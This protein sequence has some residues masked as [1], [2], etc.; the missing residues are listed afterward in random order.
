ML[1]AG[2]TPPDPVELLMGPKLGLLLDMAEKLGFTQVVIDG[3][4]L[5]GL[6]DAVVL[7]NQVQHVVF[8]VKAAA[9]KKAG[10][11]D[12]LR[13]LRH[14]GVMPMGVALTHAREE[15]TSYYGYE[16]YY[17]YGPESGQAKGGALVPTGGAAAAAPRREPVMNPGAPE[18]T[19][20]Q[21][22]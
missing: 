16:S 11:K 21:P 4:P 13:R 15:H 2:P 6:A 5:L 12:S 9:A 19:S 10:I 8:V 1:T 17:G 18:T 20:G 22:T 7:G 3:P 14:A